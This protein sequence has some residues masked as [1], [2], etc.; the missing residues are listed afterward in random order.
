MKL[1]KKIPK[2]K[3]HI[4][5]NRSCDLHLTEIYLNRY[6]VKEY[7]SELLIRCYLE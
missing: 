1:I 2:G 4:Q 5:M 7:R 3:L 6:I